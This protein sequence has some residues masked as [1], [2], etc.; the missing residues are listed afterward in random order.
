MS[1]SLPLPEDEW[2]L[3]VNSNYQEVMKTLVTLVTASLVLPIFFIKNFL[4][5]GPTEALKLHLRASAYWSWGF[6]FASLL[7]GMLFYWASAKFVKV[8]CGGR[9]MWPKN[10]FGFAPE[11]FFEEFRDVAAILVVV[12]FLSGILAAYC[13]FV[14]LR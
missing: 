3:K 12:L 6:L 10:W 4:N 11:K 9:E 8:V 5:L 14:N 2:K 13:F 7:C 1:P